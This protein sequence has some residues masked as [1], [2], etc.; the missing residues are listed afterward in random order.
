LQ[1]RLV[2]IEARVHGV[3]IV[4]HVIPKIAVRVGRSVEIERR[5]CAVGR[6]LQE[7]FAILSITTRLV[8]ICKICDERFVEPED[9]VVL[10]DERVD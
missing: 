9:I 4:V 3:S 1:I 2:D 10:L 8:T 6:K 5:L 7:V